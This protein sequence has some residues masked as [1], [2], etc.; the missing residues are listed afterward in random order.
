MDILNVINHIFYLCT[1]L[2]NEAKKVTI[3]DIFSYV[4]GIANKLGLKEKELIASCDTKI[5]KVEERLNSDY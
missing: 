1:T 2:M 5:D 3:D 4:L